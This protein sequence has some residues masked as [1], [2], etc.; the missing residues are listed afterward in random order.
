MRPRE[1]APRQGRPPPPRRRPLRLRICAELHDLAAGPD[2]EHGEGRGDAGEQGAPVPWRLPRG[3]RRRT[4]SARLST[5]ARRAARGWPAQR[6][7]WPGWLRTWCPRRPAAGRAAPRRRHRG[8][9]RTG[10][11]PP[12][13]GGLGGQQHVPGPQHVH[14][15]DVLRAARAVMG[16]RPGMHHGAAGRTPDRSRIQQAIAVKAVIT[17][18]I[19]AEALQMR[20]YR[21]TN[22]TAVPRDKM[23]ALARCR[24]RPRRVPVRRAP[25]RCGRGG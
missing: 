4:P 5:A 17:D 1:R 24:T 6:E 18:D 15:H 21:G 12:G 3:R 14:A 25:R 20:C 9:R 2:D 19:V 7:R 23:R 10:R 8:H 16:K 22:V 11:T 13:A